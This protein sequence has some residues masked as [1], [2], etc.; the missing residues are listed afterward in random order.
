M[1]AQSKI[2]I[3]AP[4]SH[5]TFFS[6]DKTKYECLQIIVSRGDGCTLEFERVL[7]VLKGEGRVL[8]LHH[9]ND[10]RK[11]KSQHFG[12]CSIDLSL[13]DSNASLKN[14]CIPQLTLMQRSFS[15]P[16]LPVK[17]IDIMA[18]MIEVEWGSRKE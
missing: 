17:Y 10:F 8:I 7:K 16:K 1:N 3:S 18:N 6:Y 2:F 14:I 11:G 13:Y 5:G 4:N 9:H 12:G 15:D